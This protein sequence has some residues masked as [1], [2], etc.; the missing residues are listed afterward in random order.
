MKHWILGAYALAGLTLMATAGVAQAQNF[1]AIAYSPTST[2]YGYAFD[3]SNR[4]DAEVAAMNNC[5][6]YAGDCRVAI[7]F[8]NAC[9][10]V[11]VG[12]GNAWGS[13]WG[14]SQSEAEYAAIN[15]CSGYAGGCATRV[16]SCT[17]R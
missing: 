5:R 4:H 2:S 13:A 17:T 3:Y 8:R 15:V 14:N 12:N 6:A 9:G 11:A 1:G 10:A 7:W 16:W